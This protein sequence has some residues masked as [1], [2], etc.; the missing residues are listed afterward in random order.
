MTIEAIPIDAASTP[1]KD[2]EQAPQI[3]LLLE[4][5]LG[6]AEIA[7]E[8]TEDEAGRPGHSPAVTAVADAV[9]GR[10]EDGPCREV[11]IA[12]PAAAFPR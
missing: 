12:V 11:A 4:Y 5:L 1:K 7:D 2:G 3:I 9:I 8:G 10:L 6:G